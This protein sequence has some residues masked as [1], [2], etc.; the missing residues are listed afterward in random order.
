MAGGQRSWIILTA[1]GAVLLAGLTGLVGWRL[2]AGPDRDD[3]DEATA[4]AD[5]VENSGEPVVVL[6]KAAAER[7]GIAAAPL[8]VSSH[9]DVVTAYGSVVDVQQL[10][11]ARTAVASAEA[12]ATRARAGASAAR[13]ELERVRTLYDNDRN[14]SEKALEQ[15]RAGYEGAAADARSARAAAHAQE[16][17]ALQQWGPVVGRWAVDG[18][19]PLDSLLERRQVLLLLALPAGTAPSTPPARALVRGGGTPVEARYLSPAS[20]TDARVQGPAFFYIVSA[21]AGL[22]AGMDVDASLPVGAGTPAAMV[23]RSAVVWVDDGAWIYVQTSDSSYVRQPIATD[24]PTADGY[25]ISDLPAGT[26]VVVR[27]AQLL[28]SQ[29]SRPQIPTGDAGDDDG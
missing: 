19:A 20:R 28:L 3:G 13:H 16:A 29:E 17:T 6:E 5:V 4:P 27:G 23:P 24:S 15:A 1:A 18:S 22:L 11:A 21:T 2:G 12:A 14:A 26:C 25:A 8:T 9:R 10:A 7:A